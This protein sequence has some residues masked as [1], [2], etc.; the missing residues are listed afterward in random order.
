MSL[1]APEILITHAHTIDRTLYP[2]HPLP[3]YK[4]HVH[5]IAH[6]RS[7]HTTHKLTPQV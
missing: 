4:A 5:I 2:L 6:A 7:T 1:K 3:V